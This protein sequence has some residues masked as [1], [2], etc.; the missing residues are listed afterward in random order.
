MA[1]ASST[2]VER[3]LVNQFHHSLDMA[4][5]MNEDRDL[6]ADEPLSI[7]ML[8]EALIGE[9]LSN[10]SDAR[11]LAKAALVNSSF[12]RSSAYVK[13]VSHICRLK[14]ILKPP[15]EAS[16][17]VVPFKETLLNVVNNLKCV[18]RLR[19]E[20]EDDV[21]AN[22][23]KEDV[24]E[25]NSLW[26][27]EGPYLEK[28]LP[29]VGDTL[30]HLTLIDYGQQAIFQTTPLLQ[31][32]SVHCKQ[33][34]HLELRNMF[35][36]TN[37]CGKF[38]K[39]DTLN[40]RC[41]KLLE[42]GLQDI[43]EC[44]PKLETVTLVTVVGLKRA[45]FKSACLK[46]LC[47][48]LATK[49]TAVKLHVPIL[50]KLQLKM[51]CPDELKVFAPGLL[52]LA[53]SMNKRNDAVIEFE[54]VNKL[55]ELL[56]GASEISTLKKLSLANRTLER[57]FLDV[58]CLHFDDTGKFKGVRNPSPTALPLMEDII[59]CCATLQVMSVGPGLWYALE[60]DM[61][62][63]AGITYP[64]WSSM[65]QLILHLVVENAELSYGLLA[66]LV[67]AMVDTLHT[68][69]VYVHKDS[70]VGPECFLRL[71]QEFPSVKKVKVDSW[72]K[73]LKFECFNY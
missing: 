64:K 28:W 34:R 37:D 70:K 38:N 40:L 12:R 5:Q 4:M 30:Q 46:V 45:V 43:N 32:L 57:V 35:L 20:I 68:L 33:L 73:G 14:N 18:E 60:Q 47:L 53:L 8:P 27:S 23:F 67:T 49:V 29:R 9:I 42:N 16:V 3:D 6:A 39:L 66:R 19:F 31:L 1:A 25:K 59:T 55:K 2:A 61:S 10:L 54:G 15:G 17:H 21:Q 56:M 22:R 41:V 48:G 26:L 58:P 13:Y 24:L 51:A 44:M 65:K 63:R 7:S 62:S 50:H 11:D 52:A 69:E 71:H 72:K 36:N